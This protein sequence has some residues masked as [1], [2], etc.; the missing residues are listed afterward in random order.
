MKTSRRTVLLV[1][2]SALSLLLSA[3]YGRGMGSSDGDALRITVAQLHALLGSPDVV[4]VD[5]RDPVS[6]DKSERKIPGALREDPEKTAAWAG[7]IAKNKTIIVYC[8]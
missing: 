1:G 7:K 5:V 4:I 6:W 8:A 3:C 2:L